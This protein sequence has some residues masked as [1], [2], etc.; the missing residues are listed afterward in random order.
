M[1]FLSGSYAMIVDEAI[2]RAVRNSL[3]DH[4]R[5]NLDQNASPKTTQEPEALSSIQGFWK[6]T[7]PSLNV[8]IWWGPPEQ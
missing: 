5:S 2:R 7:F 4:S 6:T 3:A 8:A 1:T